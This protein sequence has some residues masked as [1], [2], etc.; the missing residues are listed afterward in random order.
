ML[1]DTYYV[2]DFSN[3][4]FILLYFKKKVLYLSF[5]LLAREST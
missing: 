5:A 1:I 2:Q 4:M 3:K